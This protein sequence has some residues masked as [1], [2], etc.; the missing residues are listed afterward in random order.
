[1]P[2]MHMRFVVEERAVRKR[3]QFHAAWVYFLVCSKQD[4]KGSVGLSFP[5]TTDLLDV[6]QFCGC[7]AAF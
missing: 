3:F 5:F 2:S 6:E 1:M 4:V 7:V